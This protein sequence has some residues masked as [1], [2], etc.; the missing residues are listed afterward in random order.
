MNVDVI[1]DRIIAFFCSLRLTVVC[2]ALGLVLVFL[3]TMA[4]EPLGLYLSQAEFFRSFFVPAPAV[5][6]APVSTLP[7]AVVCPGAMVSPSAR[8][9]G[10]S[11]TILMTR[12]AGGLLS[13][14]RSVITTAK[15]AFG[16][17][18]VLSSNV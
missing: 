8:A 11:S 6:P 3:G 5:V 9:I 18:S 4:Q 12:S 16:T 17:P 2:L 1:S 15:F 14:S 10:A 13:P 7:F